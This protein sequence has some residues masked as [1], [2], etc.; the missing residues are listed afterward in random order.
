[1][2]FGANIAFIVIYRMTTIVS[3][4]TIT[5]TESRWQ[6]VRM[7]RRRQGSGVNP[8]PCYTILPGCFL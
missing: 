8:E 1:M 5:Q 6:T 2:Y 4:P 3:D 7:V